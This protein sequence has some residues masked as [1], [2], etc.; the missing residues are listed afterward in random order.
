MS[1]AGCILLVGFDRA[2]GKTMLSDFV[3]SIARAE[4]D[5]RFHALRAKEL[6][7]T[8]PV[9]FEFVDQDALKRLEEELGPQITEELLRKTAEQ[10]GQRAVE[11]VDTQARLMAIANSLCD[12]Q[13]APKPKA[14][15]PWDR[16]RKQDGRERWRG[17]RPR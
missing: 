14:I 10:L 11:R 5:K 6:V 7:G 4:E 1:L 13:P 15:P 2:F 8:I 17:G 9:H 16:N 3:I 12:L